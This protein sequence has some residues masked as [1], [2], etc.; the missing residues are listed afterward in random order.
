MIEVF[1]RFV[2]PVRF[3]HREEELVAGMHR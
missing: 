1:G 2:E 3:D